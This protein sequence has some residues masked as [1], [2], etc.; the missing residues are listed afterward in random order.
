MSSAHVGLQV[1]L[2]TKHHTAHDTPERF[3]LQ[4]HVVEVP[5]EVLRAGRPAEHLAA[6]VT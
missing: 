3:Q 6:H 1:V 5:F 4:V 2:Q